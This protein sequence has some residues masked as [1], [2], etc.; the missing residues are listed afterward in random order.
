MAL[1]VLNEYFLDSKQE[2]IVRL[3]SRRRPKT[4]EKKGE[5]IMVVCAWI[6]LQDVERR[7]NE[8][9]NFYTPRLAQ[10]SHLKYFSSNINT[11]PNLRNNMVNI[12]FVFV[13]VFGEKRPKLT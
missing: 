6:A 7:K 1:S 8:C 11:P 4:N 5:Q 9:L 3:R 10:I 12:V 13:F 2:E